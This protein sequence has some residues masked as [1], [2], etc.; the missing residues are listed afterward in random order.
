VPDSGQGAAGVTSASPRAGRGR[1]RDSDA[2][3]AILSATLGL[4]GEVGF[5]RMTID[6]VAERAGVSK[7]TL[8]LRWQ[9]KVPLVAAALQH[10]AGTMPEIPDTGTL[11]QDM[12][13][14][15]CEL[16]RSH[17]AAERALAAVSSEMATNPELRHAFRAGVAGRQLASVRIMVTRAM[18]RGELP[19]STDVNLLSILP[20]ALM[21][22]LLQVDSRRPEGIEECIAARIVG[23]F[24]TPAAGAAAGLPDEESR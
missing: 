7:P 24:F 1:P 13:L 5:A 20:Q 19:E 17:H 18:K 11:H 22:Y 10:W 21:H 12:Q 3:A 16:A 23:Q 9:G 8:Y 4:L 6:Q 14:Y 2:D 15:L